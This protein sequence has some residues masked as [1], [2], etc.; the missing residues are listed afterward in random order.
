MSDAEQDDGPCF[1][2][3]FRGDIT[4]LPVNPFLAINPFGV[5]IAAGRGNAYDPR[6]EVL[7]ALDDLGE[8]IRRI[9]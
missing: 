2:L 7:E 5:V 4:K 9:T 3:V 8:T 1:T 6:E